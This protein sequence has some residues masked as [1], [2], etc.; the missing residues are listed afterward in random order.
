MALA[1]I[2]QVGRASIL[3]PKAYTAGNHQYHNAMS[4]KDAG[5]SLVILEDELTGDKLL[6]SINELLNNS[7]KER[8]NGRKL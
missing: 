1:E 2:S 3:I 8:G 4:Y 6:N 7:Q 5:A